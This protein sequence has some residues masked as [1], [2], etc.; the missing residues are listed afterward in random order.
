MMSITA[1]ETRTTRTA[2]CCSESVTFVSEMRRSG[3]MSP[4]PLETSPLV[5]PPNARLKPSGTH[6]TIHGVV[7]GIA[8]MVN[9]FDALTRVRGEIDSII[10]ARQAEADTF[11]SGLAPREATADERL[12]QRRALAGL[13]WSKQ[14][15]VRRGALA[16]RR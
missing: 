12:V 3:P 13:L 8:A 4:S 7:A 14:I 1:L 15:P 6:L 10:A 2:H 5:H 11:F 9:P 16:R